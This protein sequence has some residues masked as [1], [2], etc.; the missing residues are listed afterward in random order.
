M[1]L[2]T[3]FCP[4]CDTLILDAK[5]CPTCQWLRPGTAG[6]VGQ[7]VWA[8]ALEAKLPRRESRPT[9][10]A[11]LVYLP[12][13]NGQI[14]A[15]NPAAPTPA[16]VITW[17]Y[18]LPGRY[19]CQAVAA[20]NDHLLLGN[21]Y[22]GG[23]PAPE[24]ELL[25]LS[26]QTGS[27]VWRLPVEGSSLSTPAIHQD[28]AYFT[29]NT[30]WLYGVDVA[31][32]R[33]LQRQRLA[34]P[35]SWAP[36]APL[37]T[38]TGLLVL[39][40]RSN[41]LLAIEAETG[42]VAWVFPTE[43]WFPYTP[44]WQDGLVYARCWD[45]RIYALDGANGQEVWRYQAPRDFSS[46]I[47]VGPEYLYVG[48]KDYQDGAA[49]GP[50]AYALHTLDRR[51][52][53]PVGRYQVP[54]HIYARPVATE[55]AVFFATDERELEQDQ[56]G[57]LYALDPAGQN[58][59]YPPFT[60]AQEF[61]SDLLLQADLVLAGT[62]PGAVY[63]IRWR[64][65][66]TTVEA[67]ELYLERED[68]EQAAIALAGQGQWE[69]AA[70]LYAQ[71]L[72]QPLRA[73]QLYL[74][75]GK[76]RRVIDLLGP[77]PGQAE[78]ALAIKAAQ[79]M[80]KA[81]QR[82]KALRHLGEYRAAAEAY[83]AAA[84]WV[85]AGECYEAA[86]A[87]GEARA[88]YVRAN[89]WDRWDNLTR[90]LELWD[91]LVERRLKVGDYA[92]AARIYL[93]RSQ[94][95]KAAQCYDR[96]GLPGEALAAYKRVP[97]EL[98]PE[99]ARQ[100]LAEL[101]N[102]ASECET[103]LHAY[104]ALRNWAEAA[105]M[106]EA[107][108]QY[109]R[110]LALYRQA[111]QPF[112]AAELLAKMARFA[113]AADL[114]AQLRHWGHAA[115]SLEQQVDQTIE[116]AGGP[117]T[118]RKDPQIEAWLTQAVGWFEDGANVAEEATKIDAYNRAAERCRLKLRQIRG[119]PLLSWSVQAE[120]VLVVDEGN[121]LHY[122]VE[123]VGWGVAQ[124]V[125]LSI[126]GNF[127]HNSEEVKL[128]TLKRNEKAEGTLTI[129]PKIPGQITLRVELRGRSTGGDWREEVP[130]TITVARRGAA[131][132]TTA[133]V[134]IQQ[135]VNR[136][137]GQ[138]SLWDE[139]SGSRPPRS[140]SVVLSTAQLKQQR[141]E[142]LRRQLAQQEANRGK[143]LE[144]AAIYGGKEMAPLELQNRLEIIETSIADINAELKKLL[145]EINAGDS[146]AM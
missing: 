6:S 112:R 82:A 94:F 87:W 9:A 126:G 70:R 146:Q 49:T 2:P 1:T 85:Q 142:S 116:Q 66:E 73:G 60:A 93:E 122:T 67:P 77:L 32:R 68:W 131:Q 75:A 20:W 12:T 48:V 33:Q 108:G 64:A 51:T 89:A 47:W 140:D 114:F 23:F 81:T 106:A 62:R 100:R 31:N 124:E 65:A 56:R 78:H 121:T 79:A 110:A 21:E 38:P 53:Q 16:E 86:H 19:R 39:S 109:E 113:E 119:E 117:R 28:V 34:S 74:H 125:I 46:D 97:L 144:Q 13:E 136:A 63:A 98:L 129:A 102:A 43:G 15:L 80:P 105:G 26:A 107:C 138:S 130:Q 123:N 7:P 141:I 3:I 30:G 18:Q 76:Y 45:R 5:Q 10:A 92:Q 101:A 61:Q 44:V 71:Q 83:L 88:V 99:E 134:N 55:T 8:V 72:A 40:S 41:Q 127:L 143:L 54:G 59:L 4:Q 133:T 135:T 84:A 111:G 57:A 90:Q 50:R 36:A 96:A 145:A 27:E 118:V 58:L 22:T 52:G 103:A 69:Q 17:R 104:E 14:V 37:L 42:Q 91:E 25:L 128:G 24:G 115:I 95:A 139:G 137:A 11:G 29:V 120:G 35:W 132:D